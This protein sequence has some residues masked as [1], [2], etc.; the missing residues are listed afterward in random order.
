MSPIVGGLFVFVM[1]VLDMSL[2]TLRLL[3]MMRGRKLLSGLIG[4]TQAAVFILAVSQV[5]KGDLNV[6]SIIGYA[7]GFGVGVVLG[8]MAEERLALGYTMFRIYTAVDRGAAVAEALRGAGHAATEFSAHGKDGDV[9]VI[10]CAVAR[11]DAPTVRQLIDTADP[12]A[13]VTAEDVRP[14][15]R[16]YFRH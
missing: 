7:G 14:M 9:T 15:Q 3:F 8:M 6:W 10:T 1:R 13:F 2:D 4:A 12:K 5:L 16:G 11:K